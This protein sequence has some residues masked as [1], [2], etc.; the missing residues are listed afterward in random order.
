LEILDSDLDGAAK[1]ALAFVGDAGDAPAER[2]IFEGKNADGAAL[3]GNIQ[4]SP[5]ACLYQRFLKL[6]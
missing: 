3:P 5:G 2:Y 6:G 4:G 1:E